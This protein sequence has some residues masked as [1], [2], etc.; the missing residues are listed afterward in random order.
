MIQAMR[1]FFAKNGVG[2]RYRDISSTVRRSTALAFS[3]YDSQAWCTQAASKSE[4]GWSRYTL[5]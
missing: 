1:F 3:G 5:K 4:H 2:E